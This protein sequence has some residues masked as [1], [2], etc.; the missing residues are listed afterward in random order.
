MI[1]K[2]NF[3]RSN[4]DRPPIPPPALE[5]M[6]FRGDLIKC[7]DDELCNPEEDGEPGSSGRRKDE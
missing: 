5:A 3:L 4:S 6:C 7:Y 2:D 1:F